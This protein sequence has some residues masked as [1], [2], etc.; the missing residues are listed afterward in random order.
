MTA[1]TYVIIANVVVW[2]AIGGYVFFLGRVSTALDRRL[3]QLEQLGGDKE[4]GD[5]WA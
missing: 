5:D 2:T 1:T 4:A 3:K